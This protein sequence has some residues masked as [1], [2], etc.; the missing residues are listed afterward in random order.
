MSDSMI[1]RVA[2]AMV[3][4]LN[5]QDEYVGGSSDLNCV[6]IDGTFDVVRVARAAIEAMRKPTD[7]MRDAMADEY[8]KG[9]YDVWWGG[10][11]AALNEQIAG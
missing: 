7:A 3:D 5:A 9:E 1:E 4:A 6:T 8:P 11:E 2:R 10:I